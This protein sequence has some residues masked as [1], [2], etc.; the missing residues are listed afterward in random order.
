MSQN[1]GL[2]RRAFLRNAGMTALVGAAGLGTSCST[3]A[4]SPPSDPPS[5]PNGNGKFD[6]DTPYNRIGTDASK[7]DGVIAQYPNEK[8]LNGMGTADMD[9]KAAPCIAK[10]IADRSQHENWG[11]YTIPNNFYEAIANWNKR[12]YNL[13]IDPKTLQLTTGVHAGLIAALQV[14]A[15]PGT[16]VLL[17]TPAYSG[18]YGDCRFTH[19]VPEECLMRYADGKYSIDFDELEK[20]AGRANVMIMCNPHNPTGNNWS[21]EDLLRVG[22]ICLRHRIPVLSD[23]IHCD[24]MA[25]GQK[26]TPWA[27]L[28]NKD[29]V[30]N[31]LTFK[32]TSKSFGAPGMK[33]AWYFSTN[34][35]YLARVKANTRADISTLGVMAS[36]AALNEG[37]EWLNQC[38]SYIDGQQ[39]YAAS[40]IKANFGPLVKA[41]TRA[42]ATYLIWFDVTGL[43][44]KINAKQQ[45]ADKTKATGKIMT[46][47]MILNDWFVHNAHVHM[48]PG[49]A[50]GLG[51]ENHIRMN[52]GVSHKMLEQA[53]TNI[54]AALKTVTT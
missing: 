20:A 40:F 37:E 21:P 46:P 6:F 31:S 15:P 13:D 18:F 39:D 24:F 28:P 16:R 45:A 4:A 19:T 23:E 14:F 9:F 53:L 5:A 22:E 7:W 38:V 54:A 47:E 17:L 27:T 41:A 35:D 25:K 11:Y 12:R 48:N 2:N 26:Y 8:I 44:Q 30:N 52:I 50:Y 10:A 34:P 1:D 43:A 51:G 33:C 36:R 29:V 32:S 3:P 42:Q 49:S